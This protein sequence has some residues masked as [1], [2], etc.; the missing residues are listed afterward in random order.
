[1]NSSF[2][3]GVSGIKVHQFGMDVWA[4]NV[5]NINNH[6][7]KAVRPEFSNVF[8]QTLTQS[9]FSP[10]FGQ[11]GLGA[12]GQTTAMNQKQGG[13]VETDNPFDMAL[14]SEGWFGTMNKS[15]EI[16]YTRRGDF[17]LDS[18][19]NLVAQNGNFLLGTLGNNIKNGKVAK[20][21]EIK[22][23][24]TAAQT[25]MQFP[26]SLAMDAKPT[27]NVTIKGNLNP[28][29]K[30]EIVSIDLD[31]KDVTTTHD[32]ATKKLNIQGTIE[33]TKGILDPKNGD[34]VLITIT[35]K[36]N[37]KKQIEA[38]LKEDK[39]WELKEFDTVGLDDTE[40]LK[41]SASLKT[42]QEVANKETFIAPI[43]TPKGKKHTLSINFTKKIPQTTEGT[44][45][46]AIVT[47]SDEKKKVVETQKG[48]MTFSKT[49]GILSSSIENIKNGTSQINF[50]TGNTKASKNGGFDGITAISSETYGKKNIETD[51]HI[52][53]ELTKYQVDK[54]G[55]IMAIFDNGETSSVARI[56]VFHFQNDQGLSRVGGDYFQ[57]S[58]NS[59]NAIFYTN[60]DGEAIPG[61]SFATKYLETSNVSLA[62][63]LTEV[64]VMQKAFD[65][66]SK[67]IT[68]SDQM[69]QKAINMK[70]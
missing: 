41:I 9:Y 8:S 7:F 14:Q 63:A 53:G 66:S 13:L 39:T 11:V 60:K 29:I 24:A 59:G 4:N 68:T 49:G 25:K 40:E 26:K 61:T 58:G 15:G 33:N 31:K 34:T 43:V 6:G 55:Y 42:K 47:I 70:R 3:N 22:L 27:T 64:I 30:K 46:D 38:S 52:A 21:N 1:M 5:S 57:Q 48:T 51:G 36:K 23:A 62:T 12:M 65:A 35:D 18:N 54:N 20:I 32:K 19:G 56:P 16:F 10:G 44:A 28:Q 2:Y 69:I 45:W 37:I 17:T 67:S 50:N